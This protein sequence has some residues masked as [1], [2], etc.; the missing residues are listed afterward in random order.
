MKAKLVK[1]E[2][3]FKN[4]VKPYVYYTVMKYLTRGEW[5]IVKTVNGYEL[6]QFLGY[7]EEEPHS[8]TSHIVQKVNTVESANISQRLQE[9]EKSRQ[10]RPSYNQLLEKVQG[11]E[12]A[13]QV[14]I[15]IHH[16]G[17]I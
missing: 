14:M 11:L 8:T 12:E 1:A 3:R 10:L 13:L 7:T 9:L 4:G 17:L 5:L 15:E 2:V 16:E 6:A